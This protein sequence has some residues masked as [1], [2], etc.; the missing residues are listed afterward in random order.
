M[1]AIIHLAWRDCY[2]I[3][4]VGQLGAGVNAWATGDFGM[5]GIHPPL[6]RV[7]A[8]L[9]VVCSGFHATQNQS[10]VGENRARR[11]FKPEK[12]DRQ[13]WAYGQAVMAELGDRAR[14]YLFL[15][16]CM[17][18]PA[19]LIVLVVVW[20]WCKT[21]TESW[22]AAMFGLAMV[23]SMPEM[24]TWGARITGEMATTSIWCLYWYFVR[25]QRSWSDTFAVG[26]LLGVA[27]L[28][29]TA[30]VFLPILALIAITVDVAFDPSRCWR[31]WRV[32]F[33]QWG[34][35]TMLGI[36]FLGVAYGLDQV[37]KPLREFR[38]VS[39]VLGGQAGFA[40]NHWQDSWVGSLPVPFPEQFV[41]GI[42]LQKYDFDQPKDCYF[43]GHAQHGG[44]WWYYLAAL[45]IKLPVGHLVLVALGIA[46]AFRQ[47][48][49]GIT[50]PQGF[51]EAALI[52]LP[53][54]VL[55]VLTS[56][57]IGHTRNVRY[58]LPCMPLLAICLCKLAT[59]PCWR[60]VAWALVICGALET[61]LTYP[62]MALFSNCIA[63][64]PKETYRWLSHS[65]YDPRVEDWITREWVLAHPELRPL[66]GDVRDM[67][68]QA[69]RNST[70]IDSDITYE[71]VLRMN[72]ETSRFRNATPIAQIGATRL[73]FRDATRTAEKTMH[74]P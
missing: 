41:S 67:P 53:A 19:F 21:R 14:W 15:G 3:D 38:F 58:L 54:I 71:I 18:L 62:H 42:D 57:Q 68:I 23:C 45:P 28:V 52:L 44:W 7:I 37:G 13:E 35:A 50:T 36:V 34:V 61:A 10:R 66:R 55:F 40:G 72:L 56:A 1:G 70:N 2:W 8:S 39:R 46:I 22:G 69:L 64:G 65:A 4:E 12:Y 20:K 6:V 30:S 16:R 9:P 31:R 51:R 49:M 27:L 5:Y 11:E 32:N 17:W 74:V 29:R 25:Q 63:G 73:V 48:I 60:M 24:L 47:W 59:V 43:G 33:C 26:G